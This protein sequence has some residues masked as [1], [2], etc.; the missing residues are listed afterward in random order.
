MRTFEAQLVMWEVEKCSE[1]NGKS[2]ASDISNVGH[3]FFGKG[4]HYIYRITD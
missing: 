1:K 2:K 3:D 4:E